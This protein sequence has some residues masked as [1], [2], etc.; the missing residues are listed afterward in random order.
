M[1]HDLREVDPNR[2]RLIGLLTERAARTLLYYLSETNL[3]VYHWFLCYMKE[4]PIPR[5]S[6]LACPGPASNA[7]I[8]SS[9][10]SCC[11]NLAMV[12]PCT[13]L[14]VYV[15]GD[16][17]LLKRGSVSALQNGHWDDVSGEGFLRKLLSQPIG[18]AK[19]DVVRCTPLAHAS[20]TQPIL[21]STEILSMPSG[22]R[23]GGCSVQ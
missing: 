17:E 10:M 18:E 20:C 1:H 11:R 23:N 15:I 13:D 6:G 14:V 21:H 19:Y 4:N 5:V 12:V 8:L 3:N 9:S 16:A 7:I 2:D 22:T